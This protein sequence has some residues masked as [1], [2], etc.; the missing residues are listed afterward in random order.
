[1]ELW[2]VPLIVLFYGT[3]LYYFYGVIIWNIGVSI[4][5]KCHGVWVCR[6][7]LHDSGF[8]YEVDWA[9]GQWREFR[10]SLWLLALVAVGTSLLGYVLKHFFP[11]IPLNPVRLMVGLVVLFVQHRYQSGIILA[12][13]LLSFL[14]VKL[15][16]GT[17]YLS[18]TF[19]WIFGIITL[20]FKESYRIKHWPQF[21]LL[22]IFFDR[23]YGGMYGWQ[24]PANFLVLRM[25]SFGIDY[26]RALLE[27][28]KLRATKKNDYENDAEIDSKHSVIKKGEEDEVSCALG[29]Y[30][31]LNYLA[32]IVYAPLY[33]AGPIISFNAFM[34]YNNDRQQQVNIWLYGTRWLFAFALLEGMTNRFPFFSVVS[35][36]L[37]P[38][39]NVQEIA[40]VF[41]VVL[42]MMW[43]K[44]MILWRF[45]R[46]WSLSDGVLCGENMERCMS[47]NYSLE[48]FWKGW[49]ST[50]NKWLVRYI[51]KP[52]GGRSYR[53]LSVWL[54]F[55]FVA[56]WHDIEWKLI[57]WGLLNASFYVVEGVIKQWREKLLGKFQRFSF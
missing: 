40:V 41:Y 30:N 9:D 10:R 5:E 17:P 29:D 57:L 15:T 32:Y 14:L 22:H 39:L 44:F 27:N 50:Y 24:L 45:F 53:F 37:L 20:L 56:I 21:R 51:Y 18:P 36:G 35:S 16:A 42:K 3:H 26:H 23:R 1:M 8:G 33:M 4:S 25:I 7:H 55:S 48:Q 43:L 19:T 28:D 13:A 11:S 6:H 31:L 52:L 46:W 2:Q 38:H 34:K 47:N 49:H 12:L 54:I